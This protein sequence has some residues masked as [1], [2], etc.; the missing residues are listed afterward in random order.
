[1]DTITLEQAS[2]IAEIIGGIAVIASLVYLG[3]QV[4]DNSV[5]VRNQTFQSFILGFKWM[6]QCTSD[7]EVARIYMEGRGDFN[8]LEPVEQVRFGGLMAQL[9]LSMESSL[10]AEKRAPG[11]F[12]PEAIDAMQRLISRHLQQPGVQQWWRQ[13]G[14]EFFAIDFKTR[15]DGLLSQGNL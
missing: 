8:R 4:R 13:E 3:I 11:L 2:L 10:D 5:S 6:E 14:H 9:L 1:M 7:A 12:K 15:V